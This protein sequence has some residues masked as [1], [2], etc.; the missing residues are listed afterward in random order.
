MFDDCLKPEFDAF[1]S[2]SG[3]ENENPGKG[4]SRFCG[5]VLRKNFQIT[6]EMVYFFLIWFR[7]KLPKTRY[8]EV[9]F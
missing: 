9:F 6:S 8:N 1:T 7:S 3:S 5:I 4:R 2:T